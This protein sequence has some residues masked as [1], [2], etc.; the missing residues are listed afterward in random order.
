MKRLKEC[1]NMLGNMKCGN[2]SYFIRID[3]TAR[4]VCIKC[5]KEIL[6]SDIPIT[7]PELEAG[8]SPS[9]FAN[10]QKEKE[11]TEP[12]EVTKPISTKFKSEYEVTNDTED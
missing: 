6:L 5:G 3:G 4:A 1:S 2:Q 9:F 7:E 8:A 12:I 11:D 10:K